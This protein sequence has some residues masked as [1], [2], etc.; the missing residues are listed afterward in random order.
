MLPAILAHLGLIDF[1]LG[2][3]NMLIIMIRSVFQTPSFWAGYNCR[4][5]RL[6]SERQIDRRYFTAIT[7][8]E[9]SQ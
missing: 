5:R 9:K 1:A 4:V 7:E 8:R 3:S 2:V 6:F